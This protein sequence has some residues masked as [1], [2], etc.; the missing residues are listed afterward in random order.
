MDEEVEDGYRWE[1]NYEKTWEALTETESGLVDSTAASAKREKRRLI[2]QRLSNVKLGVMRHLFVVLDQSQNM[3]DTDLKPCRFICLKRLTEGFIMEF[4]D[5][6]PISQIGLIM[7]RSGKGY[8]VSEL[9]SNINKHASIVQQQSGC[10]GQFSLFNTLQ[11]AHKT[12]T[13]MPSYASREV[14]LLRGV[15]PVLIPDPF[16]RS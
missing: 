2:Q 5:Q 15:S 6:N 16:R 8:K 1:G 11:L 3:E 12:L 4:Y 9:S 13:G 14:S 7:G 10:E